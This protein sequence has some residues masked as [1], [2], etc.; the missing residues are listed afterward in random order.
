MIPNSFKTDEDVLT[1]NPFDFSPS[2][3]RSGVRDSDPRMQAL[4]QS[5]ASAGE[6]DD[7][8]RQMEELRRYSFIGLCCLIALRLSKRLCL[9]NHFI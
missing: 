2:L 7:I 4:R 1:S 3:S 6:K 9:A 8:K 5:L